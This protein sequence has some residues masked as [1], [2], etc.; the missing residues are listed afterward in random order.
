MAFVAPIVTGFSSALSGAAVCRARTVRPRS[1]L[2]MKASPAMPFLECPATLEDESI[3]GNVGFDPFNLSSTFNLKFMQE[4]E[5]KHCRVAMLGALGMV[6]PE[7][8]RFPGV[9]AM[10]P[11]DAH[12]FFVKA[13]GMWQLLLW[14]SFLEI[15][16]AI[17]LRETLEGD[18]APG[19]FSF[20]PLGF[21]KDPATKAKYQLAEI[22]NGRLAMCAVGGL[23][24][25]G[26]VSKQGVL[27]QLSHFKGVPVHLY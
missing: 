22:K 4:A 17:A 7:I 14:L 15:F 9:S 2:T 26:L 8:W 13:G 24:H 25:A 23:Y 20:D 16:G 27:E 19:D 6:F 21:S 11:V 18:R 12:N 5:I 3:P 10:G 1:S